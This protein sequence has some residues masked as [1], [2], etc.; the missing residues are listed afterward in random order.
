[1]P[2]GGG[3]VMGGLA[4]ASAIG[5]K[6]AADKQRKAE[7]QRIA[8]ANRLSGENYDAQ[9]EHND[10]I[11]SMFGEGG[12]YA[13][14]LTDPLTSSS[15]TSMTHSSKTTPTFTAQGQ[16]SLNN[17]LTNAMNEQARA[18]S[19]PEFA[20]MEEGMARDYGMQMSGLKT[21]LGNRAAGRGAAPLDTDLEGILAGRGITSDFLGNKQKVPLLKEQARMGKGNIANMLFGN[22]AG[23]T[24]GSSTKGRQDSSTNTS[25]DQG[26]GAMMNYYNMIRPPEKT[27]YV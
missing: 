4:L 1:M 15:N 6:R 21:A 8:E 25:Q 26:P 9:M 14:L 24:R 7:D 23:L 2:L 22:I 17:M 11:R 19:L 13:S 20:G 27:V 10:L 3:V 18:E 5:K 16:T 12:E